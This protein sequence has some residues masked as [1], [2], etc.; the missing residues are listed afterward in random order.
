M[1]GKGTSFGPD[2]EKKHKKHRAAIERADPVNPHRKTGEQHGKGTQGRLSRGG[3]GNEQKQRENGRVIHPRHRVGMIRA[4]E[5]AVFYPDR[6]A[7]GNGQQGRKRGPLEKPAPENL[8]AAVK[9]E[10]ADRTGTQH[11][12]R[13]I[14]IGSHKPRDEAL[15]IVDV[16]PG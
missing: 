16:D 1:R 3:K 8:P 9:N 4:P 6:H 15:Q 10:Y 5:C 14:A 12:E 11:G 13:G 7:A 2:D